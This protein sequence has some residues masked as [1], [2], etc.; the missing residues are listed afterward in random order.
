MKTL[1]LMRHA[2]S[3]W[4]DPALP[5]LERPLTPRGRKGAS[6]MGKYLQDKGLAPAIVL[7]SS[8][9]RAQETLEQLRPAFSDSTVV[10]IEPKLYGA[11]STALA[12]RLRR[13]SQGSPS[14]LVI[15]HDP[16]IQELVLMLDPS[17]RRSKAVRKKFPTAAL[18]VVDVSI[19]EWKQ[20]KP[21]EASISDFITPKQLR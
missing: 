18:A 7:C 16:A 13:V 9:T 2:K 1:L 12:T 10:K 21:G 5:D 6:L 11:E 3:S 14:V 15:G 20:L 4:D 19:D 8:A 17:S